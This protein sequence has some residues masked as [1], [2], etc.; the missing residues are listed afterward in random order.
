MDTV[1]GILFFAAMMW[2]AWRIIPLSRKTVSLLDPQA[3][4][5]PFRLLVLHITLLSLFFIIPIFYFFFDDFSGRFFTIA[6]WGDLFAPLVLLY[7]AYTLFRAFFPNISQEIRSGSLS[8]QALAITVV[9]CAA[10]ICFFITSS[11]ILQTLISFTYYSVAVAYYVYGKRTQYENA[12]ISSIFIVLGLSSLSFI[13]IIIAES[14][15]Y[16]LQY[17]EFTV[18]HIYWFARALV[19]DPLSGITAIFFASA[20][21]LKEQVRNS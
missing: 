19:M 9:S 17:L 21:A 20:L 14:V 1:F 8:V 10:H 3:I 7:T 15:F 5:L 11:F 18:A 2:T 4:P 16:A 13:T 12:H 6:F